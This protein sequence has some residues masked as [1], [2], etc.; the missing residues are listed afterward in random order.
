MTKITRDS[1]DSSSRPSRDQREN[2]SPAAIV[3]EI[4]AVQGANRLRRE[5][6]SRHR[7]VDALMHRKVQCV[8][9]SRNRRRERLRRN[10]VTV[11]LTLM[12]GQRS[13]H[14][15]AGPQHP[16][17]AAAILTAS[18]TARNAVAIGES[19]ARRTRKRER[20]RESI[21]GNVAMITPERRQDPHQTSSTLSAGPVATVRSGYRPQRIAS[22]S[23]TAAAAVRVRPLFPQGR[24]H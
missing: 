6:P 23:R 20:P 7:E 11:L 10:W 17:L 2:H 22:R 14:W 19:I 4:S 18:S 9:I 5:C 8:L 13:P 15:H 1:R 3:R 24:F 12:Q 21:D 16:S